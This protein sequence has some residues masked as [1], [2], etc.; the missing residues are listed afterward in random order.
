M[1]RDR[2]FATVAVNVGDED[3]K[4]QDTA[5]SVQR[6]V[7]LRPTWPLTSRRARKRLGMGINVSET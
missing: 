7:D 4:A 6:R 3:A 2:R 5:A 1:P